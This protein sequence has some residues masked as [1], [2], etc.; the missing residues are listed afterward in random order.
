MLKAAE[1]GLTFQVE[2]KQTACIKRIFAY[3]FTIYWYAPEEQPPSNLAEANKI[4]A[5]DESVKWSSKP[6]DPIKQ[7]SKNSF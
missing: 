5:N 2:K 1:T 7:R 4:N 6:T 3:F